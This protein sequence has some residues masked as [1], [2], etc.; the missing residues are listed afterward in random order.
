GIKKIR[1]GFRMFAGFPFRVHHVLLD[2]ISMPRKLRL[3]L[4]C[5]R[6]NGRMPTMHERRRKPGKNRPLWFQL[7]NPRF[8]NV[9]VFF[10]TCG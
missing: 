1:F 7:R 4:V 10:I 8:S 3:Y 9:L 6:S 5:A 2:V